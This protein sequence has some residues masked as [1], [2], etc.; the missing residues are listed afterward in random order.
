MEIIVQSIKEECVR[1]IEESV[2]KIN[3][4]L[5]TLSF[6]QVW[7]KPNAASNC[8]GNLI[9]HLCGNLTQYILCTFTGKPDLRQRSGEFTSTPY[10]S[11]E[12]LKSQLNTVI[13]E[14]VSVI[15]SLDKTR[16]ESVYPVQCFT[17]S[18]IGIL[19]HVTEHLSY[20]TGQIVYITKMLSSQSMDF[21]DDKKL[22]ATGS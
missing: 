11:N 20:H 10:L 1:R 9:L 14:V 22:E 15:L 8:T 17:E 18:G 5:A 19:I 12:Q 3:A 21:Y 4:C 2:S 16:L 13:S 6:E 7:Y